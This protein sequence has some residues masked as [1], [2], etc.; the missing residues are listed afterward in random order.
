[1]WQQFRLIPWGGEVLDSFIPGQLRHQLRLKLFYQVQANDERLVNFVCSIRD[2]ARILKLGLSELEIVQ[3]SLEGVTPQGRSRLV[4]AERPH[5]F[6]DL[7]RLCVMSRNIQ[8]NDESRGPMVARDPNYRTGERCTVLPQ[9]SPRVP[10]VNKTAGV[11]GRNPPKVICFKCN[12]PGHIKRFCSGVRPSQ[13]SSP[14]ASRGRY[15]GGCLLL[16]V[17]GLHQY[18]PPGRH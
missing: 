6:A 17:A 8:A 10:R 5:C 16:P 3:V 11:R 9:D 15:V 13:T 7:D 4:F 12:R 1:M 18:V 2:S 14:K